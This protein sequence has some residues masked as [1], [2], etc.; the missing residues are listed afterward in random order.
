MPEGLV[1]ETPVRPKR[2]SVGIRVATFDF[3]DQVGICFDPARGEFLP[4]NV[5]GFATWELFAARTIRMTPDEARMLHGEMHKRL[6]NI[7]EEDK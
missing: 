2:A 5:E 1:I 7:I 6:G 3:E 4:G